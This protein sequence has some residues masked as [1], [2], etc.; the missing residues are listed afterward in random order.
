LYRGW[1]INP[2]FIQGDHLEKASSGRSNFAKGGVSTFFWVKIISQIKHVHILKI[3]DPHPKGLTYKLARN[4]QNN[5]CECM[6]NTY[7][8]ISSFNFNAENTK[9]SQLVII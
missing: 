8:S 1:N 2:C 4:T 3:V 7:I 9:F 6:Q 5:R